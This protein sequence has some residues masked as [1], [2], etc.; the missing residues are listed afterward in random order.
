MDTPGPS[1]TPQ[2][3]EKNITAEQAPLA[4]EEARSDGPG[5]SSGSANTP[6]KAEK[7][8]SDGETLAKKAAKFIIRDGDSAICNIDSGSKCDHKQ[9]KFDI[10]NFIRHFRSIHTEKAIA[11]GLQ[12]EEVPAAIRPR[13]VAKRQFAVDKPLI[14]EVAVQLVAKHNLPVS[15]MEWD[16]MRMLFDPLTAGVGMAK[17]D[18]RKLK[19]HV[20]QSAEMIKDAIINELKGRLI[21]LKI[22]SASRHNRHVLAILARF[23]RN[24]EIVT[25]TLGM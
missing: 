4:E 24:D 9:K 14:I 6:K 8:R 11:E 22:D 25:R 16:A 13:I 19:G 18:T 21:S 7:R 17:M 5:P 10:N 2:K 15:C 1:K 23:A 3:G 12:K 20:S